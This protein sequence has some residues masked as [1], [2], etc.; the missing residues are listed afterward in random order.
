MKNKNTYSLLVQSQ[1]K[2][3]SIFEASIYGLVILCTAFSAWQFAAHSIM[4]PGMNH[5]DKNAATEMA[6]LAPAENP[7]AVASNADAAAL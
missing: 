5:V 6:A 1:E 3:R 2:G 7:V 4:L